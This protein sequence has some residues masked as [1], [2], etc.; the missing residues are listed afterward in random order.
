MDDPAQCPDFYRDASAAEAIANTRAFIAYVRALPGNQDQRV[1]PVITPRF[2]PACTDALLKGLGALAAE[3]RCHIQTH[4]SESDWEHDF[5][6]HRCG[7]SDTRALDQFGLLTRH[8]LLAHGNFLSHDDMAHIAG[9]GAGIAHCPLSNIYFSDA[10]FPLAQALALS[11]NVGLGTDISGGPSPSILDNARQALHSARLLESGVDPKVPRA[12]R[13]NEGTRITH[14]D[15]FWLATAGGGIALDLPI[16]LL[17]PGYHFDA[18]V[19]DIRAQSAQLSLTGAETASEL[20]QKLIYGATRAH[21]A[22]TWVGGRRVGGVRCR[23]DT[24]L[25]PKP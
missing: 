6:Q 10:I 1:M 7:M 12:S 8:S 25:E 23:G 2:I 20:T 11:V 3:T 14:L 17:Q 9:I 16:G 22:E 21:I 19:I 5:V 4:C 13:R 24:A 18:L 15:A